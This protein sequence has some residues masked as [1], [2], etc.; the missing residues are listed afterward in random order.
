DQLLTEAFF[1][2]VALSPVARAARRPADP[3]LPYLSLLDDV[4]R[5]GINDLNLVARQHAAGA[6]EQRLVVVLRSHLRDVDNS[7]LQV[8]RVDAQDLLPERRH[9]Q[10][11]LRQPVRAAVRAPAQA[12]L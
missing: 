11:I 9:E 2:Q 4:A 5:F 8:S 10:G 6:Y 1:R 7:L 3:H 12:V